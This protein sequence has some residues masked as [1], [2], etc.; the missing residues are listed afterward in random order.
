MAAATLAIATG[1]EAAPRA[2]SLDGCADQF[3]MAL[4]PRESIVGVSHR[5]DDPDSWLRTRAAGLPVRRA[6]FEAVWDARPEVVVRYW[7]GDPRLLRALETRGVRVVTVE[8]ATDFAGVRANVGRVAGALGRT[9]EG[10]RLTARMADQLASAQGAWRGQDALYLTPGAYTAGRGTLVDAVLGAA[11]LR[12]VETR[13]GFRPAPLE[14]L[15]LNPPGAVVRGFWDTARFS[16]W[17]LGRHGGL[18]QMLRARTAADLPGAVL[19]CPGPM[20]ADGAR[21]LA[22]AAH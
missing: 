13:A 8:E 7:G 2:M 14:A 4:A 6:S 20:A 16:R 10:D 12:N 15:L 17:S 11:G 22:E 5:A 21:M 9:A 18:L 19:G 3:V 1:A